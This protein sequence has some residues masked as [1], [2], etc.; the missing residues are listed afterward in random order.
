VHF[1]DFDDTAARRGYCP[2]VVGAAWICEE[3]LPI[4]LECVDHPVIDAICK[5]RQ[6]IGVQR[7][8]IANGLDE[9]HLFIDHVGPNRAKVFSILRS[10]TQMTPMQAKKALENVPVLV[11]KGWPTEFMIWKVQLE[12]CGAIVRI[13]WD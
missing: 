3:H 4:A 12:E 5:L 1:A 7:Y 11:S 2:G 13:A 9:P 10:A 8:L 6:H